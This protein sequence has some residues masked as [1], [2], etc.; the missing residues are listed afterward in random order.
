MK[1]KW[2][3]ILLFICILGPVALCQAQD[4]ERT[5]ITGIVKGCSAPFQWK[6]GNPDQLYRVWT[7]ESRRYNEPSI[8]RYLILE[9]YEAVKWIMGHYRETRTQLR[10]VGYHVRT[11]VPGKER[12][13]YMRAIELKR[14]NE[15]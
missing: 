9:D 14:E 1:T 8:K 4:Y 11:R 7:F 2:T 13:E 15:N 10:L 3:I 12:R 5:T 6:D